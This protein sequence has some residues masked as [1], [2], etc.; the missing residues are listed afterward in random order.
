MPRQGVD[1]SVPLDLAFRVQ[2]EGEV[3]LRERQRLL[4]LPWEQR[5]QQEQQDG[6]GLTASRSHRNRPMIR[7]FL[8]QCDRCGEEEL[9]GNNAR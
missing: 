3:L 7:A 1:G 9:E 5:E 4:A 8:W 6:R 2:H